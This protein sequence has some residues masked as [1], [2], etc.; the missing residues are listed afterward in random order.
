MSTL[1][2][3]NSSI[4]MSEQTLASKLIITKTANQYIAKI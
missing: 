2:Q 3:L 4:K 1:K